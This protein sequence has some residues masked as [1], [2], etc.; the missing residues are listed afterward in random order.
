ARGRQVDP[1]QPAMNRLYVVE[2]SP[3]ITGSIADHRLPLRAEDIEAVAR[4]LAA[5]VGI[6]GGS[7]TDLPN[8]IAD[9][10]GGGGADL[11]A[12]RGRSLV[13]A[14]EQQ[15]AV[16]HAIAHAINAAL[17]NAGQTVVYTEPVVA[18]PTLQADSL[19]SLVADM[20]AG[21]VE[22]LVIAGGNPVY[23]SP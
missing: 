19:K 2:S 14:G 9:W 16:V 21:N 20:Q 10:L 1:K 6:G 17:G 7:A 15:P 8:V 23:T 12:H 13:I 22:L 4:K 5:A 11:Q 3:S 18:S